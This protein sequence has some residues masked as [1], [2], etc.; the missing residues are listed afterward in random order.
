V[1][2]EDMKNFRSD[3]IKNNLACPKC[4]VTVSGQH[5]G[6]IC[7]NCMTSFDIVNDTPIMLMPK[8]RDAIRGLQEKKISFE[9]LNTV[10]KIKKNLTPPKPTLNIANRVIQIINNLPPNAAILEI[11]SGVRRLGPQV[12]NVEIDLFPN[13]D[14]VATGDAI[15]FLENTFD[16][17][18]CQAVL[19]HV[20]NPADFVRDMLFVLKPG[21]QLYAEIP[22][23]QGYHADPHDYQ[24][25]TISGIEY[26]FKQTEKIESGVA[27]GPSSVLAWILR[28]YVNL[29]TPRFLYR[30]IAF[31]TSWAT[32]PL[33]YLDRIVAKNPNAHRIAGGLYY[34]GRKPLS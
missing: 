3:F 18:I 21:G 33:K 13:V 2:K 11:G 12:I 5:N 17:V 14:I 9:S 8:E 4:K 10:Q 24:R 7:P 6:Y 19:E 23:L 27:V 34:W 26:L 28:E 20:Q 31:A 25:Y 15:P 22:F 16:L 29:L 1:L 30:P 32:F